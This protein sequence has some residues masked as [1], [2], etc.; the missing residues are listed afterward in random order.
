MNH[1][2]IRGEKKDKLE[3]VVIPNLQNKISTLIKMKKD[4]PSSDEVRF[5]LQDSMTEL[6]LTKKN[7]WVLENPPR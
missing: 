7:L 4:F 6:G 3:K 1:N 5:E 2:K